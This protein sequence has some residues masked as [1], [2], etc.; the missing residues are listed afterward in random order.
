VSDAKKKEKMVSVHD[1]SSYATYYAE[2]YPGAIWN[3][4]DKLVIHSTEGYGVPL[5]RN[6]AIA[7]NRTIVPNFKYKE[8]GFIKHF[9]DNMSSRA[10]ENKAGGKETN[11]DRVTQWEI[12]GTCSRGTSKDWQTFGKVP[13]KDYLEMWNLPDWVLAGLATMAIE[14]ERA[15]KLPLTSTVKWIPYNTFKPSS[16]GTDNGVRLNATQWDNYKGILGHE[17][18]PE[19]VH[20]DPGDFQIKSLLDEIA[21][22]KLPPQIRDMTMADM[23]GS[24]MQLHGVDNVSGKT[25]TKVYYLSSDGRAFYVP[26]LTVLQWIQQ[27]MGIA[28]TAAIPEVNQDIVD[29]H[30]HLAGDYV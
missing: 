26:K 8:L 6:G 5:Y 23:T 25:W 10:L 11:R 12:V 7:P 4:L 1:L 27:K 16:Y 18:V 19:N 30:L 20:G 13:N 21:F 2:K 3:T 15:Y 17:H 29:F 9:P 14:L 28:R 22:Q 24:L